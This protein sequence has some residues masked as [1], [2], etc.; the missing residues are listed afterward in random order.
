MED[1][2]RVLVVTRAS[3]ANSDCAYASSSKHIRNVSVE[4]YDYAYRDH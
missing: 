3:D 2:A 4:N 1:A